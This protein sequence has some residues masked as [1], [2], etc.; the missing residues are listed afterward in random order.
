MIF[1]N[2]VLKN[3]EIKGT[4][5]SFD[6]VCKMSGLEIVKSE[7]LPPDDFIKSSAK[8]II[9]HFE[10]CSDILLF[11]Q[12]ALSRSCFDLKYTLHPPYTTSRLDC[13]YILREL[14]NIGL[15]E[16]FFYSSI[17]ESYRITLDPKS[18]CNIGK[19]LCIGLSSIL[20][21]M[22]ADDIILNCRFRVGEGKFICADVAC[23]FN[24]EILLVS[25]EIATGLEKDVVSHSEQLKRLADKV[26]RSYVVESNNVLRYFVVTANCKKL[27]PSHKRIISVGELIRQI[28]ALKSRES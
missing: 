15:A 23:R 1:E 25:F 28:T 27:L 18:D 11:I 20:E 2:K 6:D 4:P 24:N 26:L 12:S 14:V 19:I 9:R 22:S 17:S 21:D 13:E 16:D 7:T 10:Q 8:K 5:L 3:A